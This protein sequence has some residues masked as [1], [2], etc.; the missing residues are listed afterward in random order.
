M[1]L[2]ID[3]GSQSLKAVV[4]DDALRVVGRAG[5]PYPIDFPQPGW[6]EQHPDRWEVALAPAVSDALSAAGRARGDVVAIGIA[7]QLDGSL[8]VDANGRPL[9]PCLI[10]MDRRADADL[11]ELRRKQLDQL[12]RRRTG[13]NLDG[14]HMAPKMRWQLDHCPGTQGAARFHQPVTYLVERLT[15]EAVIDHGLASTTLVYDIGTLDF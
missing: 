7:G 11:D 9:A 10:W 4:L 15:G 14:S 2:G 13:A 8:P 12:F 1:F 5:R 3:V 6:A